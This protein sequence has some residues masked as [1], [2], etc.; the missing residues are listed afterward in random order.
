[1][2][3]VSLT[4]LEFVYFQN[5]GVSNVVMDHNHKSNTKLD[6]PSF[7]WVIHIDEDPIEKIG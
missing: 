5:L 3:N 7:I 2:A 6:I 1:M 4:D